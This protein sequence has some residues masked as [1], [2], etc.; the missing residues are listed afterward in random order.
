MHGLA[1]RRLRLQTARVQDQGG[2]APQGG[3]AREAPLFGAVV[4]RVTGQIRGGRFEVSP[5]Q[6]SAL[7]VLWRLFRVFLS[8]VKENSFEVKERCWQ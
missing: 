7:C 4:G 2:L 5:W 1:T 3:E 6:R 8:C